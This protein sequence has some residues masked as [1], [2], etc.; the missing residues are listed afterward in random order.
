MP[1]QPSFDDLERDFEERAARSRPE[2]AGKQVVDLGSY[3]GREEQLSPLG[4]Q[5]REDLLASRLSSVRHGHERRRVEDE[6]H[7]P[8]PSSN[9]ASGI[10]AI[11]RGSSSM[12]ENPSASAKSP[13]PCPGGR[14]ATIAAE[15]ERVARG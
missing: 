6:R 12:R 15:E 9:S 3:R 4:A 14:Y 7:S 13:S 1:Q 8:K 11:E 5:E 10:S 2:A